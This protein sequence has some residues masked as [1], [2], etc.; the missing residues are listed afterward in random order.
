MALPLKD[1][2]S[3]F[4][5]AIEIEDPETGEPEPYWDGG[6]TGNPALFP[7][8]DRSLARDIVVININPL[9]RVALPVTPQQIQTRINEI[10]FNSS[11]LRELRAISF[12]QRLISDG[13]VPEGAMKN[14]LVHM[15]AD[16]GL[17]RELSVATK[18]IPNP[19]LLHHPKEAGRM[20]CDRFLDTH[21]DDLNTHS[22][23]PIREMFE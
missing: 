4:L 18:L 6:Y 22:T 13:T 8:F 7:L 3:V 10:S 17:M 19:A 11:L 15:V 16:D 1:E 9:E 14:V 20:A 5:K 2:R 21:Y 12:V 23:T